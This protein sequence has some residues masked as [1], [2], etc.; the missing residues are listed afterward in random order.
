LKAFLWSFSVHLLLLGLLAY[1]H[2][3]PTEA[4]KSKPEPPILAYA[5]QNIQAKAAP[6]SKVP[7]PL[8]AVAV[9]AAEKPKPKPQAPKQ[10]PKK[11]QLQKKPATSVKTKAVAVKPKAKPF[12][13][14]R[15][16]AMVTAQRKPFVPVRKPA[17]VKPLPKPVAVAAAKPKPVAVAAAKPAPVPKPVEVVAAKPVPAP[18]PVEVVAAKPVPV[19]TPV[20]V[21]AAKAVPEPRS[22]EGADPRVTESAVKAAQSASTAVAVA[23]DSSATVANKSLR[24]AKQGDGAGSASWKAKQ[25]QLALEITQVKANQKP[26]TGR[27]VKTFADGSALIDTNPGCWKVPPAESRKDSIWLSTSVPCKADTTAEQIDAILQ[28]RRSYSRD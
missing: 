8:P 4:A 7:A 28:K 14:V 17:M 18:K 9:K 21:A 13:P 11:A 16:P 20:A 24:A 3:M 23:L 5:Y 22:V 27:K 19:S 25:Q 2:F 10:A 15:K 1:H 12:I 26:E 6:V